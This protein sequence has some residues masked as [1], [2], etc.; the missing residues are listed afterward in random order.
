MIVVDTNVISYFYLSSDY[1]ELTEQLFIKTSSWSAPMLW[2][3]EFRNVLS[4]YIRKK[5][6]T[7]QAAIQIF[8]TAESLL[9]NNEYEIN[10]V[11]VLKLSQESGCSAYDCEFIN[12]AQDL[13]V[14]LVTMDKKLLNNFKNTAVSI[15]KYI[16][17]Y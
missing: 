5:I 10:S 13:N 17:N 16:E 2:R 1:S 7:L 14:P 12:L 11:K 9:Q 6:I 4:F 15:Q 3:S 8:E